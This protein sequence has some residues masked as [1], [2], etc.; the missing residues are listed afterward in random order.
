VKNSFEE[1]Q[2]NETKEQLVSKEPKEEEHYNKEHSAERKDLDDLDEGRELEDEIQPP[3]HLIIYSTPSRPLSTLPTTTLLSSPLPI[4]KTS[5]LYSSAP[6]TTE[7]Q[8]LHATISPLVHSVLSSPTTGSILQ[9]IKTLSGSSS[10]IP[11]LSSLSFDVSSPG[12]FDKFMSESLSNIHV[13]V[14]VL[15]ETSLIVTTT[16]VT[17]TTGISY[18][19]ATGGEAD[20]SFLPPWLVTQAPKRKKQVVSPD[21]LYLEEVI[22]YKSKGKKK[23]KTLS[24]LHM[25]VGQKFV[26]LENPPEGKSCDEVSV[27]EYTITR[28]DLGKITHASAKEDAKK[29]LSALIEKYDKMK[30]LKDSY[31]AK[32]KQY[33][34]VLR[35]IM[36]S[37]RNVELMATSIEEPLVQILG[38]YYSKGKVVYNFVDRIIEQGSQF[39]T[40]FVEIFVQLSKNLIIDFISP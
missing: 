40:T 3:P 16:C 37:S 17:T 33:A 31:K 20:T 34:S 30:G 15:T 22:P 28:I 38:K 23:P 5:P 4:A 13:P 1:E 26:E 24:R 39:V 32:A 9:N 18:Q 36:N 11:I 7:V 14:A 2:G 19:L 35:N 21:E 25:E 10:S 12:G 8:A 29:S 6:P 27:E